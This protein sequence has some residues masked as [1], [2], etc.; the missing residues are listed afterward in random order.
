MGSFITL[1][2][3]APKKKEVGFY[4]LC[5]SKYILI[6]IILFQILQVINLLRDEQNAKIG[7]PL[8]SGFESKLELTRWTGDADFILSKVIKNTGESSLKIFLNTSKYSG[9]SLKYFPK[10]WEFYNLLSF[11]IFNPQNAFIKITCRIH[12]K[13]HTEGKQVYTDRFN[14][15]YTLLKGWNTIEID[16]NDVRN[17]PFKRKMNMNNIYGFGIF[18]ISQKENKTI[19]L[20][21]VL[22]K[23]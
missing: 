21:D 11:K 23:K 16:L 15:T 12:D 5:L 19:Y 6:I 4:K 17:A 18:V 8:L 13:K 9:V 3:F 14:K 7:F 1:L 22:L 20:D 10:E 2:F